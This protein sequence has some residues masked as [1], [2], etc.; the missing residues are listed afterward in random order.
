[1]SDDPNDLDRV[2]AAFGSVVADALALDRYRIGAWLRERGHADLARAVEHGDH[3]DDDQPP[4]PSLRLVMAARDMH[5]QRADDAEAEV[6]RLR[7]LVREAY[8]EGWT[9]GE[10]GAGRGDANLDWLH[11]TACAEVSRG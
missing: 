10:F 5:M 9:S 2:A 6:K 1:M 3:V 4:I 11:S 7:D 8:A